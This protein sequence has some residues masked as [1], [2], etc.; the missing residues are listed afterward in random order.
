MSKILIKQLFFR[1]GIGL[2]IVLVLVFL[3]D[4]VFKAVYPFPKNITYGVSFSPKFASELGMDWQEVYLKILSDLKVKHIRIPTYWDSLEP[5]EGKYDFEATDFM[6]DEAQ[7]RGTNVI[8]TLGVRQ[9]RWPEC[10]VPTFARTL[11]VEIRQQKILDFIKT[12]VE[13]YKFHPAIS[14]W[15][16]ENESLLESFGK[17]CDKPDVTFLKEEVELVKRLDKRPI[18]LTD[19]GELRAW[20]IPMKLSDIFGT[21]L[22]RT[23][24][25]KFLGYTSYPIL[26]YFYN[27]KSSL[28]RK[29]FAPQNQK[30]IIIELQAEPW[31]PNNNLADTDIKEQADLF[32]ADDFKDNISFAR[33]TGFDEIYLWGVEWWYFME[34]KG[35][36]S[37][38]DYA[39]GLFS[40]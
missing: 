10:Y 11:S 40:P 32:S 7:K 18:I 26:P 3:G 1:V 5:Q 23:V 12:V 36:S 4:L 28:I 39:M 20:K 13:R 33:G 31:S 9:Y 2:I 35:N 6:L 16:V 21:T 24:Y 34:K 15:E 19:S 37:Y 30:T 8:L 17:D 14:S 27:V 29:F 38:L 22:Y 25:N